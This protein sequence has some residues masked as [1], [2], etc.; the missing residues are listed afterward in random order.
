MGI[1]MLGSTAKLEEAA[2]KHLDWETVLSIMNQNPYVEAMPDTDARVQALK[3]TFKQNED[4]KYAQF[5]KDFG[6]KWF[7]NDGCNKTVVNK[8]LTW[9]RTFIGDGDVLRATSIDINVLAKIV[10][11]QGA[12]VDNFATLFIKK[13]YTERTMLDIGVLRYPDFERPYF[14]LYRIKLKAWANCHRVCWI[15]N[16]ENGIQGEFSLKLFQPRA[17]YI[18]SLKDEVKK[19]I[20][21]AMED[22]L[23]EFLRRRMR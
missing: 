19:C 20:V 4:T 14:K 9:F 23:T 1:A 6:T 10:A 8:V 11:C 17:S 15:E 22:E 5:T 12:S 3:R 21:K 7:Q 18:D 13:K 16:N 2:K